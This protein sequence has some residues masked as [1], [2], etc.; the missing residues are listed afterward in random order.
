[1]G[2]AFRAGIPR[3]AL[4][5]A[6]GAASLDADGRVAE[7]SSRIRTLAD[8]TLDAETGTI[9]TNLV[10]PAGFSRLD[11]SLSITPG[12]GG[13]ANSTIGLRLNNDVDASYYSFVQKRYRGPTGASSV[14]VVNDPHA[15]SW[16]P[17]GSAGSALYGRSASHITLLGIDAAPAYGFG[18]TF[19]RRDGTPELDAS[20]YSYIYAGAFPITRLDLNAFSGGLAGVGSRI[21]VV[22][23]S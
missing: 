15:F 20:E 1:M 8:I 16:F 14:T 5:Q 22:A 9:L 21:T 6:G 7:A 17:V 10:I 12:A 2:G 13:S 18:H 4:G 19:N 3:T 11:L 23:F